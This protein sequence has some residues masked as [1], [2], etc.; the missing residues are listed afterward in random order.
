MF[1]YNVTI[2]IMHNDIKQACDLWK[3]ARGYYSENY[4][5]KDDIDIND[6]NNDLVASS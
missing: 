6:E 5:Q 2:F 1:R 3:F 4:T